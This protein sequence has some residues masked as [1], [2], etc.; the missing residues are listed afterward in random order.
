MMQPLSARMQRHDRGGALLPGGLVFKEGFYADDIFLVAKTAD[1]LQSMLNVCDEWAV[2]VGLQFN[3]AKSR[4][5]VLTGTRLQ[6]S[7]LP[8]LQLSDQT[9]EWTDEFKYLGY[10]VYAYNHTPQHLPVDLSILN[11]VLYP[12][13]PTLLPSGIHDFFLSN[14]VDMLVTMM[15]GKVLHNSPMA[16]IHYKEM[17]RKMNKWLGNIAGLPI[18][19]TVLPFF[20]VSLESCHH[21]S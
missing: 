13:A 4:V 19:M 18:N 12:L 20:G 10:P 9:L 16:D 15:E 14:R 7:E 8:Q 6:P 2:E 1:D 3:V 21:N 11:T 5:M 17:D